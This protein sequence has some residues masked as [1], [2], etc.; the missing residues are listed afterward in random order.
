[1]MRSGRGEEFSRR[2]RF[3]PTFPVAP[4]IRSFIVVLTAPLEFVEGVRGPGSGAKA[5]APMINA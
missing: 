5:T 1:M 4:V 2:I 3:D